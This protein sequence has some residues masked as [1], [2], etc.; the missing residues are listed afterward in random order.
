MFRLPVQPGPARVA[1]QAY[2]T[3]QV[4]LRKVA[5]L[6][7]LRFPKAMMDAD[8]FGGAYAEE[9]MGVGRFVEI[10]SEQDW[11]LSRPKPRRKA[12]G[13]VPDRADARRKR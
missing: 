1:R 9:R 3:W 8:V 5:E 6:A 4:P 10:V 12:S 11:V 13:G 2:K 7:D